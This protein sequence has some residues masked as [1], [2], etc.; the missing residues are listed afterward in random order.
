MV[1]VYKLWIVIVSLIVVKLFHLIYQW[2][3]PKCNGKLPP[4]SMGYP[5]IGETI[6]F[7]KPHDALQFSTFIKKRVLIFFFFF[8]ACLE[9]YILIT[10]YLG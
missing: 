3:N 10:T 7:M 9:I 8:Y 5:I 4:G 1:D 2:S 6:E